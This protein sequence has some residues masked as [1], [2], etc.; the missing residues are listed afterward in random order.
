MVKYILGWA[1]HAIKRRLV[2]LGNQ[3]HQLHCLV[4]FVLQSKVVGTNPCCKELLVSL[5]Q[6]LCKHLRIRNH[7]DQFHHIGTI[8]VQPGIVLGILKQHCSIP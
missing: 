4:R 7:Q 3:W 5:V 6:L 1:P 8:F 2:Q